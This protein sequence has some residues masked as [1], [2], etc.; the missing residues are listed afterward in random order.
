MSP[1][2]LEQSTAADE[3]KPD[4]SKVLSNLS[5]S[6]TWYAEAAAQSKNYTGFNLA[7]RLEALAVA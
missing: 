6:L 2:V 7:Q 1:Q 5:N 3:A 4:Q